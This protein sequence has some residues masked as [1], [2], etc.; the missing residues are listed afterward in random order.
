MDKLLEPRL[1]ITVAMVAGVIVLAALGQIEGSV[2]MG[3]FSGMLARFTGS[4]ATAPINRDV[5]E[6]KE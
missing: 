4:K 1:I 5:E 6:V 2:V 3:F